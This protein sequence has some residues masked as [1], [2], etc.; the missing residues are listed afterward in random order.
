MH[1]AHATTLIWGY[2][3][4]GIKARFHCDLFYF[5]DVYFRCSHPCALLQ[6]SRRELHLRSSVLRTIAHHKIEK[7]SIGGWF[8]LNYLFKKQNH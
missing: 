8:E 2:V 6:S 7:S 5:K 4:W 3:K 1:I